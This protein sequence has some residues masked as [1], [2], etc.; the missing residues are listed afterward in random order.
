MSLSVASDIINL[1]IAYTFSVHSKEYLNTIFISLLE[2]YQDSYFLMWLWTQSS[3]RMTYI[4]LYLLRHKWWTWPSFISDK[5]WGNIIPLLIKSKLT[6]NTSVLSYNLQHTLVM[7][8]LIQTQINKQ[9]N[10]CSMRSSCFQLG[11]RGPIISRIQI[12]FTSNKQNYCTSLWNVWHYIH[13]DAQHYL[14][15]HTISPN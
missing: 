12:P 15:I 11:S 9:I 10:L 7:Q 3:N 4:L 2:F 6:I 14:I 13:T 1:W 8:N 5:F